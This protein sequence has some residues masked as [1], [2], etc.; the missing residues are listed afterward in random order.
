M[1]DG[2]FR[3][4]IRIATV[5]KYVRRSEHVLYCL[6]KSLI[7]WPDHDELYANMPF[8]FREAFGRKVSVIIDCFEV[9]VEKSSNKLSSADCWSNYKHHQTAK[10]LIGITPQGSVSFISESYGG[11]SSDPYIT[12]NCE[13]VGKLLPGDLVLADRGFTIEKV[14]GEVG[15]LLNIPAFT[16]SL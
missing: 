13:I 14:V 2:F 9:F 16:K 1:I 6:L 11:G 8:C 4:D 12:A 5:S 15:A 7:R 3:F 10:T